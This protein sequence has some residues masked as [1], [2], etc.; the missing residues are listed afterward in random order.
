MDEARSVRVLGGGESRDGAATWV[1]ED[2]LSTS[3][4]ELYCPVWAVG[5]CCGPEK[6]VVVGDFGVPNADMNDKTMQGVSVK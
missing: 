3:C 5:E 4:E 2:E 1:G 6:D